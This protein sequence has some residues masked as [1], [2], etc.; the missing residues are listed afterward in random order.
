MGNW[1][2][3]NTCFQNTGLTPFFKHSTYSHPLPW[4]PVNTRFQNIG[5]KEAVSFHPPPEHLWR[6][7]FKKFDRV[8]PYPYLLPPVPANTRFQNTGLKETVSFHPPPKHLWRSPFKKFDRVRPYPY[9]LPPVPANT[10]F[11]NTGLKEAVSFHPAPNISEGPLL[12][13]STAW[14]RTLNL[15]LDYSRIPPFITVVCASLQPVDEFNSI[16]YGGSV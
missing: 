1:K 12:K 3:V 13:R 2:I 7:P 14:G 11:Q 15:S 8:R 5:L 10:R 4:L 16:H 6:S 9:L